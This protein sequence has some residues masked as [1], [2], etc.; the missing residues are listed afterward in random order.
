[1]KNNS[2]NIIDGEPKLK[3]YEV[4]AMELEKR[5]KDGVYQEKLPGTRSLSEELNTNAM[6]LGN[7]VRLLVEKGL[8]ERIPKSGT[9]VREEGKIRNGRLAFVVNDIHLPMTSRILS[10][11]SEAAQKKGFQ[12]SLFSYR[13]DPEIEMSA[14]KEILT[15]RS[16]DGIAWF[17]SSVAAIVNNRDL[18]RNS[19]VPVIGTGIPYAGVDERVVTGDPFGGFRVLT[20]HLVDQGCKRILYVTARP[21]SRVSEVSPKYLGYRSVMEANGLKVLKPLILEF[22]M[23]P[24]GELV[25]N[26]PLLETFRAYDGLVCAHDRLAAKVFSFLLRS[27]VRCPE[28]LA[29]VGYDG[30]DVTEDLGITTYAQPFNAIGRAVVENL[31]QLIL[32]PDEVVENELI[33]GELIVRLSSSRVKGSE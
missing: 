7:A 23:D 31:S 11:M 24:S 19:C 8:L 2:S 16:A 17:P 28:D 32:T 29:L 15:S 21:R 33:P 30:L 26:E 14:I 3:K 4:V 25:G 9:Y 20:Q 18:I 27:G 10:A 5:I 22:E 13:K 1:M 12:F 6:T